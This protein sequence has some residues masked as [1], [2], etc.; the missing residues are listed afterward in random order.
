MLS[1]YFNAIVGWV[2]SIAL[3]GVVYLI[4]VQ[5]GESHQIAVIASLMIATWISR[6]TVALGF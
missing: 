5:T 2:T 1:R 6:L 3:G 4:L